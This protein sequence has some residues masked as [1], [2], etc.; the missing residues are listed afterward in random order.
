MEAGK[1]RTAVF[2][3]LDGAEICRGV[4]EGVFLKHT[5]ELAFQLITGASLAPVRSQYGLSI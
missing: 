4:G 3:S 5:A 2:D 1:Q